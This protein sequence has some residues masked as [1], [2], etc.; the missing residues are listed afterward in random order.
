MSVKR[1]S[2]VAHLRR[3]IAYPFRA[4]WFGIVATATILLFM[5][6][7]IAAPMVDSAK[8][9]D[10]SFVVDRFFEKL[11]VSTSLSDSSRFKQKVLIAEERLAELQEFATDDTDNLLRSL[12]QLEIA[13]LDVRSEIDSVEELG[14]TQEAAK[15]VTQNLL[16]LVARYR[17]FLLG[18]TDHTVHIQ[19]E[20]DDS[21]DEINEI[22]DAANTGNPSAPNAPVQP[23]NPAPA[24]PATPN[25][26]GDC[27]TNYQNLGNEV[28]HEEV[29]LGK[30]GCDEYTVTV[31]NTEYVLVTNQNLDYALG[32]E[33]KYHGEIGTN[34]SIF[35]TE[36]EI[37]D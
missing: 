33:V 32:Q 3:A 24:Q 29:V 6:G 10:L 26:S 12:D 11:S 5:I 36:F 4:G 35:V 27:N 37:D 9:G 17:A 30:N 7:A 13:L 20:L 22:V 1:K 25:V 21:V 18:V 15:Q 28:E 19:K 23:A 8:P 14:D 16:D 34:N 31:G 2:P